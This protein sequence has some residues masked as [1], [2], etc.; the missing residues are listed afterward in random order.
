MT[1]INTDPVSR[2]RVYDPRVRELVCA[3]GNPDFFPELN[4]PKS[5]LRGWLN[6]EFRATIGSESVSRTEIDLHTEIAKLRRR[7]GIL[8]AVMCLLLALGRMTGCRLEGER[9]PDG[10]AKEQMLKSIG[11]ATKTLTLSSVLK[12]LGLSKSRYHA[13]QR[14]DTACE[15]TDR[16]SC[17]K[18]STNQ[19]TPLEV[20]AIRQMATSED[21][22]HMPTSTL[23]RFA[24]RAGKVY[25]SASTWLRLI[26]ERGWRRPRTRIHPAK[27]TVGIRANKPNEIWHLDV[28]VIRLLNGTK[29][30]L[31]GVLD[32]FSRRLLAWKLEE[33]LSPTTTCELL[34][35]AAKLLPETQPIV[36]LLT[37]SGVENVNETV[38]EFLLDGVLRRVL[39]QVEIVE[40]NSLIESW[41]RGLKHS[42]LFINSL[43]NRVAVERLV[44]FYVQQF[45]EVMPHSA[46]NWRTPDEVYFGRAED[47]PS[48]LEEARR[49]ARQARMAANRATTCETC[50]SSTSTTTA[51]S[52]AA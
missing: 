36:T 19:L 45:N 21:Y 16:S 47:V 2:R 23:S 9:L 28:T 50:R 27:P 13:W 15:L 24:Q 25:A 41:W 32:N 52:E 4:I 44:Q 10:A 6:G 8:Q 18:M 30:Y 1:T 48:Q 12:V 40:S 33:K 22:R 49:S 26:R 38:D 5:T 34:A 11:K 51:L 17:P 3:T 7:V 20:K 46:L 37:D 43:D 35:E 31:H 29:L 42:Y 14:A 39:A